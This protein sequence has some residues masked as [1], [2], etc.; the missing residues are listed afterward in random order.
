MTSGTTANSATF[1]RQAIQV[2]RQ[3]VLTGGGPF[4][5]VVARGDQLIAVGANRVV[6]T[7]DPTA[8]AEVEAIR[9]ASR[10]LGTHELADCTLYAS[11]E[12]CPMCLAAIHWARIPEVHFACS[13]DDAAEAGFDDALLYRRFQGLEPAPGE[14]GTRILGH[15][16]LRAEGIEA[17]RDWDTN[18][19]RVD[20]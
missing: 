13:R 6:P 16:E 20:Y 15:P 17:F 18:P 3:S 5:A 9:T 14:G 19:D 1:L 7:C 4:G 12:P 11:S 10:A 2:A 8:H